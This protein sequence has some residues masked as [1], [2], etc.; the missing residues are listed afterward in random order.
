MDSFLFIGDYARQI[1]AD[2]LNQVIGQN[3]T[4]LDGI[5]QAAI[6]E[7]QSYLKQKFDTSR[8]FQPITQWDKS[9]VY[10]AGQTVYLNALPYDKTKT[11]AIGIL[12]LQSG[13]VYQCSTLIS[14]AEDFTA[15]HWTLLN[16]QYTTY[17]AKF[18]NNQF[19]YLLLYSRGDQ[20]FY[21]DKV[22]TCLIG[23][24]IL[25]H[26]AQLEI[27]V[28]VESRVT[29][30]FPYDPNKGLQYWGAGTAYS[31]PINTAI[32]DAKWTLG[33]NR[34]QSLLRHCVAIALY[35]AHL[36]ISPRNVPETRE[37]FYMGLPDDRTY[38]AGRIIYPTYSALG[39]L[40]ACA[41]GIDITPNMPA[42]QPTTGQRIRYGGQTKMINNY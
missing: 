9:K 13:N 11:Y 41:D 30:I 3:P 20:V 33:D 6:D 32:T 31:V 1:Q 21:K 15:S 42:I 36:R 2:N 10:T 18:P 7:A 26:T 8:A 23:S 22:Y 16:S 34:D 28:P 27:G 37:K 39:W 12:A 38:K 17:F 19:N 40:Q 35:H 24:G 29:N 25:D 14:V 5:Q 4:I